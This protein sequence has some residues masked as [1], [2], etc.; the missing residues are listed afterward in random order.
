MKSYQSSNIVPK[1]GLLKM[2]LAALVGGAAVGG[3]TYLI[4]LLFYLIII[5][6][7]GMGSLGGAIGKWAVQSGK[8]RNPLVASLFGLLTGLTIFGTLRGLEFVESRSQ[9]SQIQAVGNSVAAN[10]TLTPDQK[11]LGVVRIGRY[12]IKNM[13]ETGTKIYWLIELAIISYL[14]IS[15]PRAMATEAFCE[16]SNDW[17]HRRTRL[18]NVEPEETN[19]FLVLIK[20]P[21]L[22]EAGTLI[23]THIKQVEAGSLELYTKT[24]DDSKHQEVLLSINSTVVNKKGQLQIQEIE[25]SILSPTEYQQLNLAIPITPENLT[26][27]EVAYEAHDLDDRQVADIVQQLPNYAAIQATYLL[28]IASIRSVPV[29]NTYQLGVVFD[30]QQISTS[31]KKQDFL[32]ELSSEIRTPGEAYVTL[33][34]DDPESLQAIR[35]IVTQPVYHKQV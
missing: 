19:E 30:R 9:I 33:L 17:Y 3:I 1:S 11:G 34:N 26:S 24:V 27:T 5:F 12:N 16:S 29:T 7:I 18:G 31:Q 14:A 22:P 15:I 10:K 13:G 21:H 20:I 23:N 32:E 28:K 4:A 8:V 2:T 6:P 25:T 35:K